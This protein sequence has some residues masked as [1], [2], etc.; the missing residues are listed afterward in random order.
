[1]LTTIVLLL[2]LPTN[3]DDDDDEHHQL[4]RQS[5]I[6]IATNQQHVIINQLICLLRL[7]FISGLQGEG[8][9]Q[10]RS[11]FVLAGGK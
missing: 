11:I 2:M 3:D 7:S 9:H 5:L 10:V 8:G 6:C 4:H 1:M